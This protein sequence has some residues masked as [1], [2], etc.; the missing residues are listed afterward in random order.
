MVPDESSHDFVK[1]VVLIKENDPARFEACQEFSPVIVDFLKD[2]IEPNQRVDWV[3]FFMPY[4]DMCETIYDITDLMN[5]FKYVKP[6]HFDVFDELA[7]NIL[8]LFGDYNASPI[9]RFLTFQEP[10]KRVYYTSLYRKIFELVDKR[11]EDVKNA[12]KEFILLRTADC[13]NPFYRILAQLNAHLNDDGQ[14]H[15]IISNLCFGS[16]YEYA[17]SDHFTEIAEWLESEIDLIETYDEL[18]D[19]LEI[20]LPDGGVDQKNLVQ[21]M[22]AGINVHDEDRDKRTAHAIFLLQQATQ[23]AIPLDVRPESNLVR[24]YI[25]S[26]LIR[27]AQL[28]ERDSHKAEKVLQALGYRSHP[29]FRPLLETEHV[30][31]RRL[32]IEGVDLYSEV[33]LARIMSFIDSLNSDEQGHAMESLFTA[34]QKS[35]NDY[36]R[37]VCNAGKIQRICTFVLQGRLKNVDVDGIKFIGTEK[38]TA[39]KALGRFTENERVQDIDKWEDIIEPAKHF[40]SETPYDDRHAFF[41]ELLKYGRDTLDNFPKQLEAMIDE[42]DFDNPA[43]INYINETFGNVDN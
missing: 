3:R 17:S 26:F 13:L 30:F 40:F 24:S 9:I 21:L 12:V 8:D 39:D 27:V 20:E 37:L 32:T 38:D 10:D 23:Q 2:E 4:L 19:Q 16:N 36:D 18:L 33:F 15:H 6:T 14:L 43:L 35:F 22:E 11:G 1:A 29:G 5:G 31:G 42:A 41:L 25:D 7:G 34:L 28:Q